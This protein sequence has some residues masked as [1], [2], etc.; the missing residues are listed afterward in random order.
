MKRCIV[1]LN[2]YLCFFSTQYSL[3][4]S[5]AVDYFS[6]QNIRNFAKNLFEEKDYQR[7]AG[8]Y[9]RFYTISNSAR[10]S[11][12]FKIAICYELENLRDKAISFYQKIIQQY[13]QSLLVDFSRYQ[14][15]I[16]L[17]FLKDFENSNIEIA[18]S[19]QLAKQ[20][21]IKNDLLYL[22][23]INLLYQN[24]WS[25][26]ANYFEKESQNILDQESKIKFINGKEFAKGRFEIANKNSILAGGLSA[27]I[28]GSGKI[29]CEQNN[30]G[31]YSFILVALS[32][33]LSW[34]G[35]N[36][37][38]INSV[39]GWVFGTIG[40]VLYFGNVYGSVIAA[41]L[42]NKKQLENYLDGFNPQ[43]RL[44]GEIDF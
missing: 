36:D 12:L 33:Y 18:K 10:D 20:S 40:G 2:F 25:E 6:P 35:F 23:G 13:P 9:F 27:I 34:D 39:K 19:L 24:K 29:Y 11:A 32:G 15:S 42:F 17:H 5:L 4:D 22:R 43:I 14:L 28:P 41:K 30:D 21:L 38:G 8:E 3:A 26:A 44:Y 37:N 1:L 31:L 7:A 16:N